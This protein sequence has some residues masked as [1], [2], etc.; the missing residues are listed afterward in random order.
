[1]WTEIKVL[2]A[3]QI[4]RKLFSIIMKVLKP[5]GSVLSSKVYTTL[6]LSPFAWE[7]QK[8]ATHY[9]MIQN[10]NSYKQ[11]YLYIKLSN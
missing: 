6:G 2:K 1:M 7:R 4:Q 10:R 8:A 5:L 9:I 11:V 3:V